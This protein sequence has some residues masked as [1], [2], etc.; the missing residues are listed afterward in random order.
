MP[1]AAASGTRN[2]PAGSAAMSF[3]ITPKMAI[4]AAKKTNVVSSG[5][6]IPG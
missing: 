1:A 4:V 3:R 5:V 2:Q 6:Q